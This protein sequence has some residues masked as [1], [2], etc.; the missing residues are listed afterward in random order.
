MLLRFSIENFLSFFEK[1]SFDMFPNTNRVRFLE[2]IYPHDIPLLKESAIY[3]PN[4]SGKSNFIKAVS[5]FKSFLTVKD[6]LMQVDMKR[7]PF[8]LTAPNGK[9]IVMEMEFYVKGKYYLYKIQ[10]NSAVKEELWISGI[11][12]T[13]DQLIF[14]REGRRV[15][16]DLVE[17]PSSVE[18]LLEKNP[19]SSIL[20]LNEQFPVFQSEDVNNVHAWL[21]NKVVVVDIT[22]RIPILIQL[23]ARNEKLLQFA[24]EMLQDCDLNIDRLTVEEQ[25]FDEWIKL[26]RDAVGLLGIIDQGL[27]GAGSGLEFGHDMRNEFNVYQ[28]NSGMRRVQEFLF[29]QLGADGY[30]ANMDIQSQSDGTVRLL[31][32]IPA[33]Y[34]ALFEEKTVFID[35]IENSMHPNLIFAMV[36]YY[37]RQKSNGQLIY[38]THLSKLMDQQQLLRLDEYWIARKE[39]GM[40]KMQSLS[41][42]NIHNTIKIENGYLQ[43]RYGGVPHL[44]LETNG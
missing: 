2:H 20:P 34:A 22:S 27:K 5:F 39:N 37:S 14:R 29:R 13:D 25:S 17:N 43:G 28:D 19:M 8:R 1:V 31:T 6:Y 44:T 16:S 40:T 4:G 12:N 3:G 41:D 18:K 26:H 35:E 10:I 9:P 11:G 38:T 33:F 32:L 7:I 36:K 15:E 21:R 23:M 30:Q 24:N 42:Y